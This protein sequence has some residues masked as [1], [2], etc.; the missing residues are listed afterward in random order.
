MRLTVCQTELLT[1]IATKEAMYITSYTRWDQT[2]RALIKKGLAKEG[3]FQGGRQY[4]LEI[5][6]EGRA[7]SRRRGIA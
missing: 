4:Q 5:T 1:D 7:E 6:E 2:A 3:R